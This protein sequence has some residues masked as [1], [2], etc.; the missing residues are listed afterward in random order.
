[1]PCV[2]IKRIN[3][4]EGTIITSSKGVREMSRGILEN[5]K[6]ILAIDYESLERNLLPKLQEFQNGGNS[7]EK[8]PANGN[9]SLENEL[10]YRLFLDVIN[11][12]YM[13]PYTGQEYTYTNKAG[14]KIKRTYGLMTAMKESGV[15]WGNVFE[16]S[17]LTSERWSE[18][19]QLP[20]NERFFLGKERGER[21]KG[22]A[23]QLLDAGF[24]DISH[25]IGFH[26][27][28]TDRILTNLALSGFFNDEFL[29][30]AQLAVRDLNNVMRKF[31][32][33]EI[34]GIEGL[35]V[36]SDYRLPQV[37]YNFGA[38]KLS[39]SLMGMLINKEVI[40]SGSREELALRATT[41]V[42]GEKLSQLMNIPEADVDLLLW[43]LSQEMSKNNKLIIPHML[44][45]TDKY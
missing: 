13:D 31:G 21:V 33:T 34:E 29:K 9:M 39:P 26:G 41:A 24:N 16:V 11:F 23:T 15:N 2:E 8:T 10:G 12:C 45:P 27:Y 37:I 5:S 6:D 36:M 35:T 7:E 32:Q 40:N 14:D 19:A 17:Q 3:G 28:R 38:A 44:V 42:V 1:M 18:I 4:I 30:R 25:Y 22:F 20:Q 43:M